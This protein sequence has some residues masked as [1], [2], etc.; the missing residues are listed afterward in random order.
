MELRQQLKK[1]HHTQMMSLA[2]VIQLVRDGVFIQ[3]HLTLKPV[4]SW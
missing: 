1:Q 4:S 2:Q 3:D